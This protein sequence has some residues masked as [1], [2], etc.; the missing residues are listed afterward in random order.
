MAVPA[1]LYAIAGG[2]LGARQTLSRMRDAA[3]SGLRDPVVI[4]TAR[5]IASEAPPRDTLGIVRA[6]YDYVSSHLHFVRDPRGVEALATP[7]YLLDR[8][9]TTHLVEGDCDD[10]AI[11]TAALGKAVG[12]RA[13][14]RALGFLHPQAPYAHV[15]TLLQAAGRW[16]RLDI[17]RNDPLQAVP[18]TARTM[19]LEV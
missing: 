5:R 2:D 11:L 3:N 16:V 13:K 19:E 8:I 12:L 15:F 7:R 17:T 1:R 14:F 18:P 10:A 9:A 6:I 4:E